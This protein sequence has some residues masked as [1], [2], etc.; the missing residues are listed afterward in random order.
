MSLRNLDA[1]VSP[2]T[3]A[4]VGTSKREGS[5]GR[6]LAENLFGGGFDGPILPVHPR[7]RSMRGVLTYPDV[8]SLPVDPDLAVIATP[9]ATVPG[10]VAELARRGA[11]AAVILSAGFRER[12][13]DGAA[14]EQEIL[15]AAKPGDL[16]VVG[17]NCLGL[18][19]PGRGINASFAHVAPR[20][21]DLA[22][23]SQSGAMVAAMLD[24]A[25]DRA[26]GFSRVVSLGN[27]VDVDIGDLLDDLALDRE[28]RAVLLYVEA[29]DDARKFMSA[30]RAA[31]RMKPVIVIKAGRAAEGARAA[32]SHTGALAGSD[33]VY[34]AAF[35]RAGMLRV[36]TVAELFNAATTLATTKRPRGSRLAILTNGGGAGV[37]ATDSLV[38]SGG[39]LAELAPATLERIDALLGNAW[40]RAN[41]V[42]I[43]G[44]ARGDRYARA[45]EILLEDRGADAVL[46]LNSPTAIA[47]SLEAAQGVADAAA[48]PRIPVLAS[49]LGGA[50]AETARR[51]L[52]EKGVPS[53]TTPEAATRAFLHLVEYRRSREELLETPPSVVEEIRFDRA[54]AAR[55]I[56][57]ALAASREW[58][59]GHEADAL[60]SAYGVPV[61][62]TRVARDEDEAAAMA[63][64][65][66]GAVA[67]KILSPDVPHKTEVSGVV[68][69]LEGPDVVR[70]AARVMREN[71]AAARPEARLDGFLV[72]PM[73]RRPGAIELII[74]L[75]SDPTF[76]PV[77]LFGQGG[78][79][80]EAFAD[81][82]LA[83]P[84]L[85]AALARRLMERTRVWRVLAG[86]RGRGADLEALTATLLRVSQVAVDHGA[87]VELD[88]NP[89]LADGDGVIAVDARVRVRAGLPPGEERLAIRPYPRELEGDVVLRDGER[90][91]CRPIRPEDEPR[92]QELF[93]RLTPEDVRLRF[94]SPLR[95]L[96]HDLAALLT[97][98]DYDRAMAFVALEPPGD[99][100][101]AILGVVRMTAD[102][103]GERGEYA[104][105]VRSDFQGHGLGYALM[106]RML[107]YARSRGLRELF[108]YVL[109]DNE[110]MLAMTSELGFQ[111]RG[112][113]AGPDVLRVS[114]SL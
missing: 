67:L 9:A 22:F 19:V 43:L 42:D 91:P 15:D 69:N 68:L 52:A 32:G 2:R 83:L 8:A 7:H 79:A 85:N 94:F 66:G 5:V 12:G 3:I 38:E 54:A 110:A 40:S 97:Q 53:Y 105:T 57:G 56:E 90:V 25:A 47:S 61:A 58:L 31:A 50:G 114:L 51:L 59:L 113:N 16:R 20:A 64:E 111:V 17:P 6:V 26:I 86:H 74:G 71:L 103:D 30:A 48:E 80:V 13:A 65:I 24:W 102:P 100:S 18:L 44:D 23:V 88:I 93:N 55:V 4:V 34:D 77:L 104:V 35:R 49:W 107:D 89:L 70:D 11:R 72:Q 95:V 41:P 60:L 39:T 37:L 36:R 45:L 109:R 82:A 98:L 33:A 75:A 76:G 101:S 29:I 46:V 87:V 14:L 63:K 99:E 62:E 92:L 73:I 84:P 96:H 1:L 10:I 81:K 27:M 21:G 78:T 28:T 108:G 106:L 112:S